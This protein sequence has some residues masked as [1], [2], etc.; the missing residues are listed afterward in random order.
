MIIRAKAPFRLEFSGGG[1]DV[2]P[3][4]DDHGGLIFNATIDQ[5]AYCSISSRN[6][7]EFKVH[8][9]DYN[10]IARFKDNEDLKFDGNLDLVKAV[11]K[12]MSQYNQF[13]E[14]GMEITL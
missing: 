3:F 5:Y 10:I 13:K 9:L 1:T 14:M 8:S 11:I 4:T 2:P 6:D 7:N 12:R